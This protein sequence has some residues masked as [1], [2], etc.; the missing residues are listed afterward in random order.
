MVLHHKPTLVTRAE[1]ESESR[2]IQAVSTSC[3]LVQA[4]NELGQA[5][6]TELANQ[7]GVSKTTAFHHLSTLHDA[8]FVVKRGDQY[9]L[10]LQFLDIG[11]TIKNRFAINQAGKPEVSTL[12]EETGEYANLVVEEDGVGYII[13]KRRGGRSATSSTRIGQSIPL[14]STGAGKA[15][16]AAMS[17]DMVD[18]VLA[19]HGLPRKTERTLTSE[20]DL[21]AEIE[22]I[23]DRGYAVLW[24]EYVTGAGAIAAPVED[25]LTGIQGA[26]SVTGPLS[27]MQGSN[28]EDKYDRVSEELAARV[29]ETANRIEMRLHMTED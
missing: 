7:A 24:G 8:G 10:S 22:T 18:E 12:A 13:Q 20:A 17:D 19:T 11:E 29:V 26:I 5:G 27:W 14:H 23:R 28:D 15:I 9:G 21:R 3:A 2:Q 6:V 1:S 4:L 25:H 16:L